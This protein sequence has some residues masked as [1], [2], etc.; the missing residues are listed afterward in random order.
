M[1]DLNTL[2][3]LAEII[4]TIFLVGGVVFAI[5][6]IR[7][8]KQQ[9]KEAAAI[10]MMRAWQDPEFS[11]SLHN[12]MTAPDSFGKDSQQS[13]DF[14]NDLGKDAYVVFGFLESVGVM[15][16]RGI[17]P[18][19]IAF[20]LIGGATIALWRKYQPWVTD[21]RL[22]NPRAYEWAEGLYTDFLA[23]TERYGTDS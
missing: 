7:Q 5:I 18:P 20:D 4:G 21:N 6:Q 19:E 22:T 16:K 1:N 11:K 13:V 8:M 14:D 9:R 2:A 17:L 15:L 23:R 3:N 12:L 10:E